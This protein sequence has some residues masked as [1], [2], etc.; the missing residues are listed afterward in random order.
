M[1]EGKH[2]VVTVPAYNEERLIIRS[3]QG[4]PDLVDRIIVVDDASSDGTVAQVQALSDPRVELVQHSENGGVGA[5]I[6]SGYEAFLEG[7]GDIC[8]VMGGDA[9]MDPADLEA[10][11]TPVAEDRA[12]Y[13]KGNRLFAK[14]VSKVMPRIASSETSSSRR[15][16]N[17]PPA[18]GTSSIRSVDTRR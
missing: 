1:L 4:M 14:D 6:V 8:V 15:S 12:D 10:L 11:V 5:A 2:I 17:G 18:T 16:P 7:E 13:S 9:Q 3:L